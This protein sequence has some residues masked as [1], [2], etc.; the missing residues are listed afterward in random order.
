ML[1]VHA[2]VL[3]DDLGDVT[4]GGH[5]PIACGINRVSTRMD[6]GVAVPLDVLVDNS[7]D[8][9]LLI[10]GQQGQAGWVDAPELVLARER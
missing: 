9:M 6:L 2:L 7:P 4:P 1:L 8:G 3:V 5:R 10:V